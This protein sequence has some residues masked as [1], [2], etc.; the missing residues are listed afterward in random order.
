M[1]EAYSTCFQ[2]GN[3]EPE[4]TRYF[5]TP[6]GLDFRHAANLYQIP[7][8]LLDDRE[9]LSEVLEECLLEPGPQILEIITD[10]VDNQRRHREVVEAVADVVRHELEILKHTLS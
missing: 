5:A 9:R 1:E 10:R 2:S 3:H 4:F 6:H 7:Y 8:R